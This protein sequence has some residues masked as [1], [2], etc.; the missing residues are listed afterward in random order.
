MI[1]VELP[2]LCRLIVKWEDMRPVF[3]P[4]LSELFD[5]GTAWYRAALIPKNA[6]GLGVLGFKTVFL[7]FKTEEEAAIFKLTHL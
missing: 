4:V 7:Q 5:S 3:G 1:E 2:P 6:G